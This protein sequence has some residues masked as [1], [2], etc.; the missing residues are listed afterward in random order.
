MIEKLD[1][2]RA[3]LRVNVGSGKDRKVF[4]K[5]IAYS[6]TRDLNAQY[7]AFVLECQSGTAIRPK[8]R[9]ENAK[10]ESAQIKT[11]CDIVAL[12]IHSQK[13]LGLKATT[14]RDYEVSHKR[15]SNH[16]IG[17]MD[18]S[19]VSRGD[20]KKYIL[21][22]FEDGKM[23]YERKKH[24]NASSNNCGLSSKSIRNT[25]GL[26]SAAY[27]SAIDDGLVNKN[28]CRNAHIPRDV[29]KEKAVLSNDDIPKFMDALDDE[30]LDF[31][32]ACELA[33][34]CGMRRS[35]I[36]G[37][38]EKHISLDF[39]VI[40]IKQTRAPI[41]DGLSIETPKTEKSNRIIGCPSAICDDIAALIQQHRESPF[42]SCS[43]LIQD[44]FGEPMKHGYLTERIKKMERNND[45]PM[46]TFHGL[47][48]TCASLCHAAGIDTASISSMLGHSNI[49]T[50]LNTYTHVLNGAT[51]SSKFIASKMDELITGNDANCNNC[52]TIT[53]AAQ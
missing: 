47:R 37:L 13:M 44:G 28:P 48:H 51:N 43:F 1:G 26:M 42:K 36:L 39:G 17:G 14:I 18:A 3:R 16:P 30:L 25:I 2:K 35:E 50:T 7:N 12:Y 52:A 31:K 33:L 8:E 9:K 6:G 5:T 21:Y 46:V 29:K 53:M 20:V 40:A 24:Y 41:G 27:N 10:I 19:D 4:T 45:L 11:V 34:F 49:T 32:V 22:L 38:E 23:P 15:I